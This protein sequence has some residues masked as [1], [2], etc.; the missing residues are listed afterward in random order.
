MMVQFRWNVAKNL[1]L[2]NNRNR[3][4]CFEDIVT[5]IEGGGLLD[6]VEHVNSI[7]YPHQRLFIVLYNNYVYAVPYVQDEKGVFLKTIYPSRKLTE[8]Y[9][10]G[11]ADEN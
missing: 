3:A 4:V 1:Q 10:E 11:N 8:V 9:L 7:K 6:D 5:A 2:K